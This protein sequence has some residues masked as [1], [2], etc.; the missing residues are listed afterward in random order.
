[1]TILTKE[2]LQLM[3]S[4]AKIAFKKCI[5]DKENEFLAKEIDIPINSIVTKEEYV[6]VQYLKNETEN[7]IIET[8]IQLLSQVD[9]VIGSYIYYEDENGISTDDSL[10]FE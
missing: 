3:Y 10:V 2:D 5:A 1:M 7:Y 4:K 8:K 9:K 6:K